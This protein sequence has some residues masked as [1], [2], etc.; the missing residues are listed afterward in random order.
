MATDDGVRGAAVGPQEGGGEGSSRDMR[1]FGFEDAFTKVDKPE[2]YLGKKFTELKTRTKLS[3]TPAFPRSIQVEVTNV[4]NHACV[5]CGYPG[6]NR[7]KTMI[8]PGRFRDIVKQC[9]DLGAREVSLV[10]GEEPLTNKRL[11]EHVAF[12]RDLGYE[13]IYITTNGTLADAGRWG[14]LID[15]GLHSIKISI[16]AADRETYKAIHGC[17]DFD[18]A[19]ASVRAVSDYRKT[20]G[21][22]LFLG[23]SCVETAVNRGH[24]ERLKKLIGHLVDELICSRAIRPPGHEHKEG[25]YLA[26]AWGVVMETKGAKCYQPFSQANFSVEGYLRACCIEWNNDT[27]LEDVN[28]MTVSEAWLSHRF[29][30]LRRRHIAES[31]SKGNLTG[32]LCDDCIYGGGGAFEPMNPELRQ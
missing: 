2:S 7:R 5:F 28:K 20:I 19:L 14:R 13:Y 9:Y 23:V 27:A 1:A 11:E 26:D 30:S 31:H 4:C 22:S 21:R 12:C 10:G 15:A 8:D 18:K 24:F 6:M 25:V 17:D 32:L 29:R 3:E 16:N